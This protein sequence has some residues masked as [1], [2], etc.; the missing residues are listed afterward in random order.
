M[1]SSI[2][3]MSIL[4]SHEVRP[5][6]N[7]VDD[8]NFSSSKVI[9]SF[10]MMKYSKLVK[11]INDEN[12]DVKQN[13]LEF[14]IDELSNQKSLA[15]C[16]QEGLLES[17]LRC[18]NESNHS[19]T[20]ILGSKVLSVVCFSTTIGCLSILQKDLVKSFICYIAD[21][22]E[23][24]RENILVSLC[25]ISS[26]SRG[27][28]VISNMLA[29]TTIA[30]LVMILQT[31]DKSNR[32]VVLETLYNVCSSCEEGF[33]QAVEANVVNTLIDIIC[34]TA[35]AIDILT[36]ALKSYAFFCFND[37][38]R[39]TAQP[40]SMID[41][42]FKI[43]LTDSVDPVESTVSLHSELQAAALIALVA[44]TM[45]SSGKKVAGEIMLSNSYSNLIC[46]LIIMKD[47][48]V[49]DFE[50]GVRL[51]LYKLLSNVAVFKPIRTHLLS[52]T[53]LIQHL[54]LASS[55]TDVNE[56]IARHATIALEA[57]QWTP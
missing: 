13:A 9:E 37:K 43:L 4:T 19:K 7:H 11:Q 38:V 55:S 18:L 28:E 14:L 25:S 24:V 45:D 33:M 20:R 39:E 47:D 17:L 51:N 32:K 41:N 6:Q 50:L 46:D 42:V 31:E 22:E 56:I 40:T 1:S 36:L 2:E 34:S 57:I 49:A 44:L 53:K 12:V 27:P 26:H 29:P 3:M 35:K 15:A 5:Q 52:K 8:I 54:V 48:K 10:G 23:Q 21:E 16:I 30:T